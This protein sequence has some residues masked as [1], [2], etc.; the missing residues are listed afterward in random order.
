MK[1]ILAIV[2][3]ICMTCMLASCGF[4][5]KMQ[6][7][8]SDKKGTFVV[9]VCGGTSVSDDDFITTAWSGCV[10]ARDKLGIKA[11][12]VFISDMNDA[13]DAI[14]NAIDMDADLIVC[15]GSEF[16]SYVS[17]ALKKYK[18]QFFITIES[19][20]DSQNV[21]SIDYD[22]KSLAF[23]A[24]VAAAASTQT[25]T[26]GFIGGMDTEV[27]HNFESGFMQGAAY[28]KPG[29]RIESEYAGSYRDQEKGAELLTEL[30]KRG[31]DVVFAAAGNTGIGAIDRA[32]QEKVSVIGVD[33]DQSALAPDVVL[34]SAVK[35]SDV[36]IFS[37]INKF[38]SGE[39]EGGLKVYSVLEGALDISDNAEN[40]STA[41]REAVDSAKYSLTC[42]EIKLK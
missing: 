27:I 39:F 8:K 16:N 42:G 36:A 14:E 24:G 11:S 18:D 10:K 4:D 41:A 3:V 28:Q 33:T 17:D 1:R 37:E 35:K 26:V 38:V 6:K 40:L 22:S 12:K 25:G 29:I 34:C 20:V 13:D 30:H 7:I 15:V 23:L 21:S 5:A 2:L 9:M 32:Q 19:F 31:C